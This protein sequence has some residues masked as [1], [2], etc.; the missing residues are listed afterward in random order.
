MPCTKMNTQEITNSVRF[1]FHDTGIQIPTIM[2][3]TAYKCSSCGE[4]KS[5]MECR[6]CGMH[7]YMCMSC[8]S[9]ECADR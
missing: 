6:R 1:E 2:I 5:Y 9:H 3:A 4:D 8:E 7:G